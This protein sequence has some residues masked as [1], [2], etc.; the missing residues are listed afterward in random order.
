MGEQLSSQRSESARA[1]SS[2]WIPAEPAS[3]S[4]T[5]TPSAVAAGE[6][7]KAAL[8]PGAALPAKAVGRAAGAQLPATHS[9]AAKSAGP[10]GGPQGW[11]PLPVHLAAPTQPAA[12]AGQA[13]ELVGGRYRLQ[14]LLGRGALTETWEAVHVELERAVAIKFVLPQLPTELGEAMLEEA[15]SVAK[16]GHPHV[17]EYSDFG[18]RPNGAPY[19]VME[20]LSGQTLAELLAARQTLPWA[21]AVN[22]AK[23]VADALSAAHRQGVVH[24][25][26]RPEN[27]FMVA[28]EAAGDFIEVLDFG[29]TRAGAFGGT[30]GFMS[31]EQCRGEA[32]DPRSDVYALGCLIF[33]M[34]A[35]EPPFVGTAQEVVWRQLHEAPKTMAAKVPRQF[36]S[37][38]L[39][40]VVAR[41]LAKLPEQRFTDTEALGMELG[42]IAQAASSAS[43]AGSPVI[44][45]F[46]SGGAAPMGFAGRPAP[47]DAVELDASLAGAEQAEPASTR[48]RS[49]DGGDGGDVGWAF[50]GGRQA[51]VVR[52]GVPAE[53]MASPR[54]S[55]AAVV[56]GVFGIAA[57]IGAVGIAV[58][59][60]FFRQTAEVEGGEQAPTQDRR[61]AEGEP[62]EEPGEARGEETPEARPPLVEAEEVEPEAPAP[63]SADESAAE[64]S[65]GESSASKKARAKAT[66]EDEAGAG[67]AAPSEGEQ[68][69]APEAADKPTDKPQSKANEGIE[70]DELVDP[71]G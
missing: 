12:S 10:A 17:L 16:I 52:E 53:D 64:G 36:I 14:R 19:F 35:G 33:A 47:R 57:T 26:L 4:W 44:R 42:R 54:R 25:D 67:E 22:V 50:D 51:G 49:G 40:A 38:E 24:R 68:A 9:P 61:A 2:K 41:C 48:E 58:F 63:A 1:G 43:I 66:A 8:T 55:P 39:E 27:I 34:V 15:R 6:A 28:A 3:S 46:G 29:L 69:P 18:R 62:G 7:G 60:L 31:P 59:W 65:K 5:G 56:A 21:R 71:W 37:E 32:L 45:A 11:G 20:L 23:Q 70:L 30:P 13:G